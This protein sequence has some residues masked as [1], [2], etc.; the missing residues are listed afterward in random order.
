MLN[1]LVIIMVII[2]PLLK[3]TFII[4][5]RITKTRNIILNQIEA[6]LNTSIANKNK[7]GKRKILIIIFLLI[8]FLNV[9]RL[10]PYVFTITAQ[11]AFTLR[12]ALH[13]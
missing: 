12:I 7:E 11:I 4:K 13:L 3:G 6:E 2:L 9:V 5:Q 10:F 1:Y 8:I